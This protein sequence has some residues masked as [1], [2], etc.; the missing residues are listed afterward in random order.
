M[1][2]CLTPSTLYEKALRTRLML[3]INRDLHF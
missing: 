1:N 2:C 3:A